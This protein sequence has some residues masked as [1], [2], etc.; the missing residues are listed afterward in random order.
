MN[1][2]NWK[3][4]QLQPIKVNNKSVEPLCMKYIERQL[5][6]MVLDKQL[7]KA[8]DKQSQKRGSH[9]DEAE[10]ELDAG[11]SEQENAETEETAETDAAKN[12]DAAV[13]ADD[14]DGQYDN[15]TSFDRSIQLPKI[16][17]DGP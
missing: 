12:E 6:K 15:D 8:Y 17:L 7:I 10:D 4:I 11:R 9:K 3:R 5:G 13:H 1:L 2:L 14:A 16:I